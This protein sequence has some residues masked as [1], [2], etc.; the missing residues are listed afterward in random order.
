[1]LTKVFQL[2]T[3]YL[4]NNCKEKNIVKHINIPHTRKKFV[5][6]VICDI[7]L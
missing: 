3:F 7:L 1:M 6:H 4:L 5:K 2:T